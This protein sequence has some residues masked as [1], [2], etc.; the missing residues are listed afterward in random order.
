MTGE[1]YQGPRQTDAPQ[2][3]QEGFYQS[4]T[5][6]ARRGQLVVGQYLPR[7]DTA[8]NRL[9]WGLSGISRQ[10][11]V[12]QADA[13]DG[14]IVLDAAWLNQAG[15]GALKLAGADRVVVQQALRLAPGARPCCTRPG[16]PSTRT[17]RRRAAASRPAMCSSR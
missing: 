17:C 4:Q 2:R 6:A 3:D 15:L 5:A 1:V 16:S 9:A 7:F 10:V 13:A 14:E 12:G 8:T 11:T